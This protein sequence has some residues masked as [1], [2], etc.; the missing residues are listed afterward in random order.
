MS[1]ALP[2]GMAVALALALAG[3]AALATP[4]VLRALPEPASG[5]GKIPYARLATIRFT[6]VVAALTGLATLLASLRISAGL[7][8]PWLVLA[9]VGTLAGA[10]DARTTWLPR[11]VTWAGWALLAVALP[12]VSG[13]AGWQ[14]AGRVLAGALAAGA[15]FW[16][17]WRITAAG[18]GFGDVRLM[19]LLGAAAATLGWSAWLAMLLLSTL[20]GAAWGIWLRMRGHP[21]VFA[22]APPLLV[23]AFLTVLLPI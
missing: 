3:L 10:I 22:Y 6:A 1:A 19:P 11:Q 9:A 15:V 13:L 5:A 17:V 21:G 7:L 16:F 23:G 14:A 8:A 18:I 2:A 4:R 20:A 12:V